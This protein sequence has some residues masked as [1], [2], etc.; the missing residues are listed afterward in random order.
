MFISRLVMPDD[1]FIY[2]RAIARAYRVGR[3]DASAGDIKKRDWKEH[4][5]RYIRVDHPEFIDGTLADGVSL[6]QLKQELGPL[7]FATT[8][9][10]HLGGERSINLRASYARKAHVELTPEAISWLNDKLDRC[11]QDH[12]RI[13]ANVLDDF[14]QPEP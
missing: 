10:R 7:A 11:L 14:V 6:N 9:A 2:G 4:W 1:I 3:D 12:G 8:Q 13:S 5:S